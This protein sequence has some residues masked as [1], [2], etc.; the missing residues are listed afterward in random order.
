MH[1]VSEFSA[2]TMRSPG[3]IRVV[4]AIVAIG[5]AC[6]LAPAQDS[7]TPAPSLGDLA[8]K[9]RRENSS[10]GHVRGKTL[11]DEENDGP[12]TTGVW[13]VRLCT[14]TPCYEL[15]IVLPREL[16][17]TR[18]KE[19]PRAVLIPLP[20]VQEDAGRV[21]RVYVAESP[22]S[23]YSQPDQAKRTFLQGWFARPEYFGRAAHIDFDQHVSV[24]GA[25]GILSYFTVVT[26]PKYRGVSVIT[27]SPNGAYG[28]ACAFREQDLSAALS[29][30][31]AIV[32]STR[33]QALVPAP[34]PAYEPDDPPDDPQELQ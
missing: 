8:R 13:R 6:L 22:G 18:Q 16:K 31:E 19:E 25:F 32:K 29:I 33:A 20:G 7:T 1:D 15:S 5:C 17:W 14:R 27:S 28:F 9:T 3:T 26:T 10:P 2:A 24:D 4:F 23:I 11:E 12:D 30:C 34:L 21:I